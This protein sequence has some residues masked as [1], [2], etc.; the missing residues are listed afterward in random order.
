[1]M[2]AS[3]CGREWGSLVRRRAGV[4]YVPRAATTGD[5]LVKAAAETKLPPRPSCLT[6]ARQGEGK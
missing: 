5:P 6:G 3:F 4:A 1:M 2:S